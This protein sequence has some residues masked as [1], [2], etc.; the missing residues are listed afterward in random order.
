MKT[1]KRHQFP[2]VIISYAVWF[3]CRFNLS[4]RIIEDLLADRG[5]AVTRESKRLWCT[6][7]GAIYAR[8]LRSKHRGYG[9]VAG[10]HR[11]RA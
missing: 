5:I 3:Y 10:V 6:K 7:C 8:R 9:E 11:G 2:L 1:Y 4:D